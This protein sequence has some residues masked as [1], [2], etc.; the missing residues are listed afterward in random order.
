MTRVV[1]PDQRDDDAVL[2]P[3]LTPIGSKDFDALAILEEIRQ[4]LDLLAVQRDDAD[5]VLLYATADQ[6]FSDLPDEAGFNFILHEVTD[7]GVA[8]RKIVGIDENGF[9]AVIR[10]KQTKSV[11]HI[12]LRVPPFRHKRLDP[13]PL[14]VAS[15]LP[16]M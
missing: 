9:A 12:G 5:L 4:E 16:A 1:G 14:A 15:Q 8:S 10:G 13:A 3:P 11:R 7:A 2:V 6:G